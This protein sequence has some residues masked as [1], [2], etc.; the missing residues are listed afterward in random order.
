MTSLKLLRPI[1]AALVIGGAAAASASAALPRIDFTQRYPVPAGQVQHLVTDSTVS[2]EGDPTTHRRVENWTATA[3]SRT[4]VTN[5]DTGR[6]TYECGS[7]GVDWSCYFPDDNVLEHGSGNDPLVNAS[8]RDQAEFWKRDGGIESGYTRVGRSVDLGRP[9]TVWASKPRQVGYEDGTVPIHA[10]IDVDDEL[11]FIMKNTISSPL[12]DGT[13]LRSETVVTTM[14]TL[15]SAP[16]ALGLVSRPGA[17]SRKIT[18][19]R[20]PASPTGAPKA[21]PKAKTKANTKAKSKKKATKKH[22]KTTKKHHKTTKKP[23]RR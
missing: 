2:H 7:S 9:V 10:T 11:G 5:V 15:S 22:H 3:A 23:A 4:I 20:V 18:G 13:T 1:V 17:K 12:P 14:E 6:V 8:W 16:I 19:S 21:K